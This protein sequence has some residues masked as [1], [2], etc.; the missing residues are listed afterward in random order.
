MLL[1]NKFKKLNHNEQIH[2]IYEALSLKVSHKD[3]LHQSQ[4]LSPRIGG[5][6]SQYLITKKTK[7]SPASQDIFGSFNSFVTQLTSD[8]KTIKQNNN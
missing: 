4:S 6:Q 2:P 3:S 8:R 7:T 5:V 1:H